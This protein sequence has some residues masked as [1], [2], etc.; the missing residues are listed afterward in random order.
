MKYKYIFYNKY[1]FS[2]KYLPM[3]MCNCCIKY[4]GVGRWNTPYKKHVWNCIINKNYDYS[5]EWKQVVHSVNTIE[6]F[7]TRY[8]R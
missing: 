6:S 3:V 8:T 4:G 7:Y 1:I 2:N 5:I